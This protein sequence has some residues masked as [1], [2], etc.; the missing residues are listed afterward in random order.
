[1]PSNRTYHNTIRYKQ[2]TFTSVSIVKNNTSLGYRFK[3]TS[4]NVVSV[5]I[6][7]IYHILFFKPLYSLN[8]IN[9]ELR[10]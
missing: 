9:S 2:I 3:N 8:V 1:M 10:M 7:S 6:D 4:L 5:Q